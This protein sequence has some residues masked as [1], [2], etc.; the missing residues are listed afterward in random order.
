MSKMVTRHCTCFHVA[1][2][3]RKQLTLKDNLGHSLKALAASKQP[4]MFV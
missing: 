4:Q 3:L 1:R 2:H